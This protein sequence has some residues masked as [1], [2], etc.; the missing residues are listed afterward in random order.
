VN[1]GAEAPTA[2]IIAE[3]ISKRY[4]GQVLF[5]SLN[6]RINPR[7]KVGLVGRN[8]HGKTTL[9]RIIT[10]EEHPDDG[11]ISAPKN[12]TLG[13][14][15]QRLSFTRDTV[16][17]EASS[18]LEHHDGARTWEAEKIL[19]GLGFSA[20]DMGKHPSELSGGYQVRLSLARVLL[21][22]PNLLL[23]DEPNNYLD[24]T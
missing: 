14:L 16:L 2:M 5:E 6:F 9:F 24:I 1:P 11:K 7:E 22:E 15:Q 10:G 8:G 17:G 13:Y 21:S 23:L 4:G 20:M 19:S 12:Y 18:V 3:N